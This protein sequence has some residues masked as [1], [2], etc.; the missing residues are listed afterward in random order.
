M[1][2]F[3]FLQW[4]VM[5]HDHFIVIRLRHG[6]SLA[7][8]IDL[9]RLKLKKCPVLIDVRN[10]SKQGLLFGRIVQPDHEEFVMPMWVGKFYTAIHRELERLPERSFRLSSADV[11]ARP[12]HI[13]RNVWIGFD[14]CVLPGVTIGEGSIVGARSVVVED[15]P[16]F[17]I[18]VGNPARLVRRLE[19]WDKYPEDVVI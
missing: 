5:D 15:V 16:P 14:S 9:M 10:C 12:I 8:L 7:V 4:M 2:G 3:F 18:V 1:L 13:E 6:K 19:P 11:V 17:A